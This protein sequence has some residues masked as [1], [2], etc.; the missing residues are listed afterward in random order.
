MKK[1]VKAEDRIGQKFGRLTVVSVAGKSKHGRAVLSCECSCGNF[2]E[3]ECGNLVTGSSQSCGCLHREG[4]AALHTSHGL[5]KSAEYGIWARMLQ[6]CT[7][8]NDSSYPDYG[9][10][11]IT[12]CPEWFSFENF[13]ADMGPRPSKDHSIDRK[14]NDGPYCKENCRWATKKEQCN[15]QRSNHKIEFDGR[16]QTLTQWAEDRALQTTTLWKRLFRYGWSVE[17]A[18]TTP[19]RRASCQ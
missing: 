16:T 4:V 3:V 7:N 15:N 6:R 5:S 11:G 10:R 1:R 13:Y 2:T 18:L 19:P 17:R 12:V 14:G 8:L 9:G